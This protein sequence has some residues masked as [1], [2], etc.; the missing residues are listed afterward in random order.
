MTNSLHF[1]LRLSLVFGLAP[2]RFRVFACLYGSLRSRTV[3]SKSAIELTAA[4]VRVFD[5]AMKMQHDQFGQRSVS[6][7]SIAETASDH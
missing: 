2:R 4:S 3:Q 1:V 5:E 7:A 6:L